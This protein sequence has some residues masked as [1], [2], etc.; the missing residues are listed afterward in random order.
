MGSGKKRGVPKGRGRG[1]ASY[2]RRRSSRREEERWR[3]T[4]ANEIVIEV[5]RS[6]DLTCALPP[7]FS[8]TPLGFLFVGSSLLFSHHPRH[9][10]H[11]YQCHPP[12]VLCV[13]CRSSCHDC[14]LC[15]CVPL[16]QYLRVRASCVSVCYK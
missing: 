8:S 4:K 7:T 10:H 14:E 11:H 16:S 13:L 12:C 15:L 9:H 6:I 3:K 1:G 2:W 5:K